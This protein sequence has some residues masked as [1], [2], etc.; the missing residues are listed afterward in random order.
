M[1][2][3]QGIGVIPAQT[4][5]HSFPPNV[6]SCLGLPT[7]SAS[8]SLKEPTG[9][10]LCFPFSFHGLET[11][12]VL[13]WGNRRVSHLCPSCLCLLSLLARLAFWSLEQR[14][15]REHGEATWRV[16]AEFQFGIVVFTWEMGRSGDV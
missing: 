1:V 6:L 8:P 15:N 9:F 16:L 2:K 3:D 14:S 13:S 11:L 5:C 12:K 10:N 4:D 7:L